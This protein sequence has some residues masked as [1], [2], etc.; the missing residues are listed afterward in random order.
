VT[1]QALVL[2]MGVRGISGTLQA[3]MLSHHAV[4]CR[5]M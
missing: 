5:M 4:D 2:L 1:R 3:E